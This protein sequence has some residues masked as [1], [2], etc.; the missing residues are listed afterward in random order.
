MPAAP[1][2]LANLLRPLLLDVA[3]DGFAE[4]APRALIASGLLAREADEIAAAFAARGL[5]EHGAAHR[6]RVGRAAAG[7]QPGA[8]HR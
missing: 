5:A 6:G 4:P 8:A 2:V 7:P 3:A 1:T